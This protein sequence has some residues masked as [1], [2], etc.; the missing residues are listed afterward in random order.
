M[1]RAEPPK[2]LLGARNDTILDAARLLRCLHTPPHEPLA[3]SAAEPSRKVEKRLSSALVQRPGSPRS[4]SKTKATRGASLVGALRLPLPAR[5]PLDLGAS[6]PTPLATP[7]L[8]APY[9]PPH[10]QDRRSITS[11]HNSG[12]A[13]PRA[14]YILVNQR[15][16]G[17]ILH[18]RERHIRSHL[19]H[20]ENRH[21]QPAD[22]PAVA[23]A[24]ST[25]RIFRAQRPASGAPEAHD[26][27]ST[28]PDRDT[29]H[30]KS[31][32]RLET[33]LSRVEPASQQHHHTT[34][35]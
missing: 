20:V 25:S 29:K 22:E 32:P 26:W 4:V 31:S 30:P 2:A 19:R 7:Y 21:D 1:L 17:R 34:S 8:A 11:T 16:G 14:T 28:R 23:T 6:P 5:C 13:T 33:L 15:G 12:Q 27:R 10:T 35:Q 3:P 9:M 18:Q 24:F